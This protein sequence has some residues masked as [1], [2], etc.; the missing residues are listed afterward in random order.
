MSAIIISERLRALL[1]SY[2]KINT[3]QLSGQEIDS[4]NM[5]IT[6]DENGCYHSIWSVNNNVYG[7]G[8]TIP[9]IVKINFCS[10][11]FVNSDTDGANYFDI[12]KNMI[13][14]NLGEQEL[15]DVGKWS[16]QGRQEMKLARF[17]REYCTLY[18]D[19][20]D[21]INRYSHMIDKAKLRAVEL[22]ATNCAEKEYAVLT[23]DCPSEIYTMRCAENCGTLSS[24]C[25]RNCYADYFAIYDA[26]CKIIY[27]LNSS[28]ELIGRALLW[29][30]VTDGASGDIFSFV[31]RIYGTEDYISYI[32]QWSAENGLFSK[33]H[34]SYSD[35]T[36]EL[37]SVYKS[38]YSL[39]SKC[40]NFNYRQY[41]YIDTLKYLTADM[42]YSASPDDE[43]YREC[44]S[45]RGDYETH[46]GQ[47][48]CHEC[49][50]VIRTCH[51]CGDVIRN[52]EEQ[53]NIDENPFCCNCT[54]HSEYHDCTIFRG[55]YDHI[56]RRYIFSEHM[57]DYILE[58]DAIYSNLL[59]S[60]II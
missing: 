33:V 4:H 52:G 27:S 19:C 23:S 18:V 14:Y 2:N 1:N 22:F 31:D 56:G 55:G 47:V 5:P 35:C 60:Y 6:E 54:R 16:R 41:P 46:N 25:M 50:D 49:G 37:N 51:E 21:D 48:T 10:S 7:Y 34:Q 58:S 59:N 45:T 57:E 38:D 44:S 42:F 32:K 36:L 12:R 11:F 40:G 43:E 9:H 8:G 24:S 3:F 30:S 17:I 20:I 53:I 13:S 29:I 28:G 26:N 39:I 15:N